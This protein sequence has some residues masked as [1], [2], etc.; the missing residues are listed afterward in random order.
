VFYENIL[1]QTQFVNH[2]K[3][4]N[5]TVPTNAVL[6]AQNVGMCRGCHIDF[7]QN[8][9]K[10]VCYPSHLI[11][12][13]LPTKHLCDSWFYVARAFVPNMKFASFV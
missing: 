9:V 6:F 11:C 3:R 2:D 4:F 5:E 13:L 10:A 12:K 7:I 1:G 8:I